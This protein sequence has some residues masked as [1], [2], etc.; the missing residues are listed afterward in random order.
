MPVDERTVRDM[1][2]N[3]HIMRWKI[4][5]ELPT[6]SAMQNNT[7]Y[8]YGLLQYLYEGS[9][10]ELGDLVKE[11]GIKRDTIPY[12]NVEKFRQYK[13]NLIHDS[14]HQFTSLMSALFTPLDMTDHESS[15]VGWNELPY[16]PPIEKANWL[17]N[18]MPEPHP[19]IDSLVAI[20][21]M[22]D[23][24]RYPTSPTVAGLVTDFYAEAEEEE[25]E[26]F[27]GSE[28]EGDD[29]DE[30]GDEDEGEGGDEDYG[31]YGEEEVDEDPWPAQDVLASRPLEDRFFRAGETLRGKYNDIEI[32]QFMKLLGVKPRTQWQDQSTYHHKLGLHNYEDE[33]QEI[34]ADYHVLSESERKHTDRLQ[35]REFRSGSEVKLVVGGRKPI[36][37]NYRF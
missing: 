4:E 23:K 27:Y 34:D 9:Y 30:E 8:E 32:E 33:A 36:T 24:P 17:A 6:Y 1:L 37:P 2:R 29:D 15:F 7:Q 20:E 26:E 11:I 28:G 21:E 16:T 18:M 3:Q 5:Q 12:M 31:D 10:G 22:E 25:E 14:D 35:T 19:Q 13:D